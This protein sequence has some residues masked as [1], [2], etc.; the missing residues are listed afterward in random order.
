[1]SRGVRHHGVV[2]NDMQLASGMRKSMARIGVILVLAT[3]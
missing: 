3:R 2:Y 1:M